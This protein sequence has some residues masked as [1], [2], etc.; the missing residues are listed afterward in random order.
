MRPAVELRVA[1]LEQRGAHLG[2]GREP[3][4]DDGLELGGA[5]ALAD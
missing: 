1:Y 5:L 4:L 3:T 2:E